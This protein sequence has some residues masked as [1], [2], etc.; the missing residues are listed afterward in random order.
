MKPGTKR[1]ALLLILIYGLLAVYILLLQYCEP[2]QHGLLGF[3]SFFTGINPDGLG[4]VYLLVYSFMT[5]GNLTNIPVGIPALYILAKAIPPGD[6]FWF[7]LVLLALVAGLGAGTGELGLYAVGRG[8]ARVL[9]GR[10]GVK[11]LQSF[12]RLMTERRSLTPLL[13]YFFGLTPLPDQLIIIPLGVSRYPL[14][15]VFFP[16]SLGKASFAF[17][18]AVGATIFSE[19]GPGAVTIAS[20]IQESVFLAIV[21]TLLVIC[22]SI[23]WQA[24]V[25]RHAHHVEPGDH[26]V[27]SSNAPPREYRAGT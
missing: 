15:K 13:L 2:V 9:R 4:W 21:L 5:F 6:S 20:L 17:I 7:L 22:I 10:E 14:K 19:I 18:I 23:N 26:R 27:P 16:C 12:V 11:N 8:A 24:V 25:E 1:A 3:V